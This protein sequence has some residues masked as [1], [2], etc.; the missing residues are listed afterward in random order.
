MSLTPDLN[1]LNNCPPKEATPAGG[2]VYRCCQASPPDARDME[3]VEE[4]NRYPDEPACKRRAL[5]VYR[6]RKEAL[7]QL[8]SFRRWKTKHLAAGHLKPEH[9]CTLPTPSRSKPSHVSWW[10][11]PSMTLEE[12]A[13]VFDVVEEES[14]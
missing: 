7:H 4:Q 8:R 3:T 14:R 12:R 5:S 10:P 1:D 2:G 13:S 9:G 11:A 6:S